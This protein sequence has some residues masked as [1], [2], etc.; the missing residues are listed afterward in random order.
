MISD[1]HNPPMGLGE[2][3]RIAR[4]ATGMS[5]PALARAI[6][7]GQTTIAGYEGDKSEPTL[8]IISKIAHAT[9]VTPQ[10]L[11]FGAGQPR[12]HANEMGEGL[13]RDIMT[14]AIREVER[15]R[16]REGLSLTPDELATL[17]LAVHDVS[18][19]DGGYQTVRGVIDR[20]IKTARNPHK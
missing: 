10:W 1:V 4:T 18:R 20:I 7:M 16:Q 14:H 9:G 11:A 15:T 5:Q 19:K 3:I 6:N 17:I 2:R 12:P 8:D 13:D